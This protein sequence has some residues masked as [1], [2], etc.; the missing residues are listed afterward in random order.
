M[1]KIKVLVV[2]DSA[3]MR[4]MISS[5]LESHFQIIVV[6]TARN[7][8]DALKKIDDLDPDV[9]TLDIEMPEMD[10]LTLLAKIMREKP[11][12]VIMLSSLTKDGAD[13]TFESMEL[14]AVDFIAKPSGSISLN[15]KEKE[16]EI[17]SK[18]LQATKAKID[19]FRDS[20]KNFEHNK[21]FYDKIES[22]LKNDKKCIIGIGTSTGGPRA[23]QQV[24]TRLPE[25]IPAPIAIVQHMPAGFTES[26][27]K[28]L[29]QLSHVNVC[30]VKDGER[31]ENGKAYI[32]PGGYQF[33]VIDTP[34][35]LRAKVTKEESRNGHQPS[36]DVLFESLAALPKHQLLAVIMTGM[37]ADGVNGLIEMKRRKKNTIILS[38]AE[39]TCV[40]YGMPKVAER[41]NLVDFVVELPDIA[42]TIVN[43]LKIRGE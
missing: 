16:T 1:E 31:L 23:L 15:I 5:I 34:S 43:Q 39:K 2:D 26:L 33:R 22:G 21:Q 11:R 27:A 12:P 7:G 40:V 41:T 42:D 14:G 32:A 17:I 24:I 3:F 20:A 29:D 10:G 8:I 35:G 36:V 19:I 30:E 38:E 13:K 37:G 6:G 28:R 4:K 25:N 9:I 18:V